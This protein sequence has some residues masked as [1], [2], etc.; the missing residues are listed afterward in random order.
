MIAQV[1]TKSGRVAGRPLTWADKAPLSDSSSGGGEEVPAVAAPP[2][3]RLRY[4]SATIPQV[5]S[6]RTAQAFGL[7]ADVRANLM[8]TNYRH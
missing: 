3:I 1:R 8:V 5:H 7:E 2:R 4:G 6:F